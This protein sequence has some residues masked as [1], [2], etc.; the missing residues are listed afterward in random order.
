MAYLFLALYILLLIFCYVAGC[1]ALVSANEQIK[2]S[3]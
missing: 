3:D 1:P 2:E